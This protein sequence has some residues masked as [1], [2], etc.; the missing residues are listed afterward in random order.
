MKTED[1]INDFINKEK[2]IE[3]S[4][5]LVTRIMAKVETPI[6]KS[7][8][9]WQSIAVA[10]SISFVILTGIGIGSTYNSSANYAELNLNDSNI[11]NFTLYNSADNE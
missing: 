6:T 5:F 10:A 3:P 8:R 7:V 9:L 1:Y 4:P 2:N 11:E